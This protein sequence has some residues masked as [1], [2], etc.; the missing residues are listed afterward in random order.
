MRPVE[1]WLSYRI[2]PLEIDFD[3]LA[4]NPVEIAMGIGHSTR[5][6]S[7]RASPSR[8]GIK[9]HHATCGKVAF[10]P[11]FAARNRLR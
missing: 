9:G 10:I 2:L 3:D 6:G 4:S 5:A 11:Y 7:A 1:K 8:V